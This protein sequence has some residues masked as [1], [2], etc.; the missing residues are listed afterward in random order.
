MVIY[1]DSPS[2]IVVAKDPQFH[3]S[4]KHIDIKYHF[5]REQIIKRNL[6]LKYCKSANMVAD[7]RTKDLT[8]ERFE[9][10]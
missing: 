2:A 6:G 1:E 9:K 10:L 5:I 4:P 7:I 8:G 3:G